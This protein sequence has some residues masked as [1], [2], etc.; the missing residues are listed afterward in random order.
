MLQLMMVVVNMQWKIMT[1]METAQRVKIALVNAEV[2]PWK[3]NVVNVMV[4]ALKCVGMAVMSVMLQT[5]QI[6]QVVEL[7]KLCMKVTPQLADFNLI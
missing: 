7:W 1:V 2:Q 4:M 6:S 3:M 5:A